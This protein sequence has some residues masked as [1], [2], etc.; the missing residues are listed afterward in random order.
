MVR[1]EVDVNAHRQHHGEPLR[2]IV[3]EAEVED[4]PDAGNVAP[5]RA[6]HEASDGADDDEGGEDEETSDE[7]SDE[8]SFD[9]EE[10]KGEG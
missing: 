6:V 2:R 1:E 5:H 8:S 3:A 7:S 10:K 4:S 9:Q